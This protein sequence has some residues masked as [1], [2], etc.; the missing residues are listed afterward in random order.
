MPR[1]CATAAAP[2]GQAARETDEHVFDRGDSA[3]LRGEDLRMI[4]RERSLRLVA[5]FLPEPEETLDLRLA[6][7]AVLPLAGR[8]PCEFRRL[9]RAFQCLSRIKQRL[10]IHAVVHTSCRHDGPLSM[11]LDRLRKG[12]R[13]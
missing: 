8:P 4:R 10:N 2:A 13:T 6:E 3:I 1:F 9:R 11:V 7:C 12:H 5:L